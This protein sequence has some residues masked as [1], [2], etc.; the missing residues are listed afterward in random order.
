[1]ANNNGI[2]TRTYTS[3]YAFGDIESDNAYTF[4]DGS[5]YFPEI[6][7]GRIAF[8]TQSDLTYF[9]NKLF[10]YER[11]P[12]MGDTEWYHQAV[13]VAGSDGGS[14]IS[15]RFTKL[16]CREMM[17][18][19]GFTNVD[20]FFSSWFGEVDPYDINVSIDAGAAYVNYRGYGYPDQWIPPDYTINHLNQLA[21]SPRFPIM[22]SI[23]CA[24]G[25]YNDPVDVC[26]GETWIRANNKGGAGFIGNSNHDAHTRWTNALDVGI[27]WGLF[28]DNVTTQAQA[29]LMGKM[30]VYYSFPN[31]REI[32]GQVELYFNSY[33]ILGDPETNCWTDIPKPMLVGFEATVPFGQNRVDIQVSD[34][35]G[36]PL[37]GAVACIWKGDEL[38]ET[39][40]TESNGVIELPCSPTTPGIMRLTVTARGYIPVEDT[41]TFV[42]NAVA[43]G[44][45]SHQVDDD[46]NGQSNGDN[47]GIANPTE[48]LEIPVTLMNFGISETAAGVFA[49]MSSESPYLQ[50]TR[51]SAY[52]GDIPIED[53]SISDLPYLVE[54][55]N[56]APDGEIAGL[57]LAIGDGGGN[58][59]EGIIN[60]PLSAAQI[61]T[62]AVT[63]D[64]NNQIDPG[65]SFQ[66]WLYARNTGS[67]PL[68]GATAILRTADNQVTITDSI[69]TFGDIAPGDSA[70]NSGDHFAA[71]VS[72]DIFIGH[73][74][75][76]QIE[77]RGSGSQISRTS[78]SRQVGAVQSYDPIGP[79]AYGYY[80]YDNTDT[81]YDSHPVYNWININTGWDYVSL[82]DD[83]V[84]TVSLPFPVQYYGQTFSEIAICDN[85][86]ITMGPSWFANFY[87][88][89]IP[90]PQNP[91]AMIAPFW[92]DFQQNP[93]RVY[94]HYDTDNNFFIIGW[95]NVYDGDNYSYQTFEIIIY[96]EGAYPTRTDDNEFTF[97]YSQAL[98][99]QTYSVGICSP[100]RRVGIEYIFNDRMASGAAPLDAGRAIKFTTGAVST[101]N[102]VP[103]DINGNGSANG[104][105]VTYGVAY[106]KGGNPPAAVCLDCPNPGQTLFGAGDV[107]GNCQ[108]NGIDITFYVS[109]LK[110]SQPQLRY[111]D[112]CPPSAMAAP[113]QDNSI[114]SLDSEI[115]LHGKTAE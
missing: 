87:N 4:L 78:F 34:S 33:N 70:S 41:I 91:I 51:D 13:V 69:G 20:T 74:I 63:V 77:F 92:D 82:T 32:D 37:A 1:M 49:T 46:D 45:R 15:P 54:I 79:D 12:Y 90:A 14:F 26:F 102:Y 66:L 68:N 76:F 67:S 2:V 114:P 22:T 107:N 108:F 57:L 40:F 89:P 60:L 58:N 11:Y 95:N 23:V 84:D 36:I 25:D 8:D 29:Q 62:G 7:S 30:N 101:C 73:Q 80:C 16:W 5:D 88:C 52:Y 3:P 111:C 104:I 64:G 113:Q 44:Y 39:G 19:H 35:S 47:N 61:I 96:D 115:R 109:Y 86:F 94:Y 72:A 103:G 112:L 106:F 53:S 6:L 42:A 43:V 83:D 100:D 97:Q 81:G 71:T 10:T 9:F 75:N 17:M 21:N 110:G 24:T 28:E 18:N 50:V 65:E 99:G 93:M 56:E 31:D 98:G 27:Y 85:G 105:D 55:S 48:I 59:W 38:F